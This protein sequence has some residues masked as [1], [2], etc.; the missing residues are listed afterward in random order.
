MKLLLVALRLFLGL[1]LLYS[2]MAKI[3]QPFEFLTAVYAYDLVGPTIGLLLAAGLPWL[4]IVVGG[5]LVSG[6]LPQ[7]AFFVAVTL[8]LDFTG[9][10]A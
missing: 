5:C 2:G 3:R 8:T 6:W 10:T 9:A 7:G 1:L 4:E